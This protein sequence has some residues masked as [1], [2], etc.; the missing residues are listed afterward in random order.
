MAGIE[1]NPKAMPT[2]KE[3]TPRKVRGAKILG[4]LEITAKSV[5]NES[6]TTAASRT[7]FALEP[8]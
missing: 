8:K 2:M 7:T 1:A 4:Q 3:A 6:P 5:S